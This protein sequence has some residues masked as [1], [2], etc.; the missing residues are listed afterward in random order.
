MPKPG[1]ITSY[2]E[3]FARMLKVPHAYGFFKGRVALYAIL[4]ALGAGKGDYVV[5]PGFT[6]IMVPNAAIYLGARPVYVDIEPATFNM[7]P[8]RLERALAG[9][10][11]AAVRR[12]RAIVIQHTFGVPAD[13][14]A[15]KDIAQRYGIPVVEDCAHSLGS[16]LGG[17]LTGTMGDAAFFSSQWSKPYSTGLGGIAV[18]SDPAL[19]AK[20]RAIQEGFGMPGAFESAVLAFQVRLHRSFFS[21]KIYW[22]AVKALHMLSAAGIFI[23]SS[24]KKEY[25]DSPPLDYE[26]T[27][28]ER[29]S[30]AGLVA[31]VS[32][33]KDIV[34]RKE[35][36]NFYRDE[37][38]QTKPAFTP[39]SG[40]EPVLLRYPVLVR[41]KDA[42]LAEAR[43][44]SVE[45]GSWF[46]SVLHPSRD[47]L[48]S[49]GYIRGSCPVGERTARRIVNLPTHPRVC[50]EEA[51]RSL[52]LVKR[53]V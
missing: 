29:Q 33:G 39:P 21:P 37:L 40:T 34:H 36:A 26:K 45:V 27:I 2:E 28:G 5:F 30:A 19:G 25:T 17:R 20:L 42:V 53:H 35:V 44:K 1:T 18:T 38:T 32:I 4:K 8:D 15:V 10:D 6:C 49:A 23:G 52:S 43:R 41:D 31:L 9:M 16:K 13:M 14:L 47:G 51:I 24:S 48:E 12:V 50:R 46:E 11:A 7:D 22:S 3:A